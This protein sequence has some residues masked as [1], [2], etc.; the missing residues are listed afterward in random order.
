MPWLGAWGSWLYSLH[1][2]VVVVVVPLRIPLHVPLRVPLRI[3]VNVPFR[4][5]HPVSL[6][7]ACSLSGF[8][9]VFASF[10]DIC[11]SWQGHGREIEGKPRGRILYVITSFDRGARLGRGYSS[12]DKMDYVLMMLDEMREACEVRGTGDQR[13]KIQKNRGTAVL[14][15]IGG[16]LAVADVNLFL[17]TRRDRRPPIS[18]RGCGPVRIPVPTTPLYVCCRDQRSLQTRG[19]PR[20]ELKCSKAIKLVLCEK[21]RLRGFYRELFSRRAAMSA[22]VTFI[23]LHN[24]I[25]I[26]LIVL[27]GGYI[28]AQTSLR[29]GR[30]FAAHSFCRSLGSIV[31]HGVC[32]GPN[33]LPKDR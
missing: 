30:I 27:L 12:V 23:S 17:V 29:T 22:C 14:E 33:I 8:R 13:V 9:F 32:M 10:F 25:L 11:Y 6:S 26:L 4:A 15:M 16:E 31:D 24:L 3:P 2:P 28:L 1:C 20:R 21:K 5:S 18:T 19:M 7:I